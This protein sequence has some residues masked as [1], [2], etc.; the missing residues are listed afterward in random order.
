MT[1]GIIGDNGNLRA[2]VIDRAELDDMCETVWSEPVECPACGGG[3]TITRPYIAGVV[4]VSHPCEWCEGT[5]R[6]TRA[7]A[8]EWEE[9]IR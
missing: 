8:G 1:T 5:G 6:C 9:S 2:G 7:V 3:C 4:N